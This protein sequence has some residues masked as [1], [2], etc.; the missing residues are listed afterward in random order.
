[1]KAINDAKFEKPSLIQEKAI[2]LAVAGKDVMA[3]SATGSG[4]TLAF[5]AALI[6]RSERGKGIQALVLTPTRELAEQNGVELQRFSRY[7][8]LSIAVVYGGV[9]INPQI[10]ALQRADLVVGTPGRILDHMERRTI[11]FRQVKMLVLDEADRMLDMGFIDDVKM[12]ISACPKAR[13]TMLFSATKSSEV[14]S[15]ARRYMNEPLEVSA[16]SNVDP[17][18]LE[19]VYYDVQDNLKFSL[20][21][22]LLKN[23][24]AGLVMVFCN[25]RRNADFVASNLCNVGIDATAIHGGLSQDKRNRVLEQFHSQR[26]CVMVCTDVAARGLDIKGVSHV[27][28]YDIPPDGKQY[29]HRIGRTARAGK[30]GKAVSILASRDYDNFTH[31]LNDLPYK[32]K[33]AETP[34]VDRVAFQIPDRDRRSSGFGGR[35]GGHGRSFGREGGRG[36]G[37]GGGRSGDGGGSEREGSFRQGSRPY[38]PSG[39]G[40]GARGRSSMR[41]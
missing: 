4:K 21:V 14:I 27:Y 9:G 34:Y 32:I 29:T 3:W 17:S 40:P 31:V 12:I 36:R 7:K 26:V 20:L 33:R 8:P 5:G 24:Q 39:R 11:D 38:H 28:N 23:E 41:H 13:Q 30:E 25:S 19:Q 22:H 2:P 15:L 16:E 6:Q 35:G 37:W 18:K 10:H 1:M